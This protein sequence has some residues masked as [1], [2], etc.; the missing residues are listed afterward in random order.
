MK[1]VR[2]VTQAFEGRTVGTI[3][4]V[5][6]TP[7]GVRA[8]LVTEV[9]V[10]DNF[11]VSTMSAVIHPAKWVKNGVADVYADPLDATFTRQNGTFVQFVSD[12]AKVLVKTNA[13]K[14]AAVG[15]KYAEMDKAI[16]DQMEVVFG[17]RR[18]DSAAATQQTMNLMSAKPDLFALEG[19]V[20]DMAVTGYPLGTALNTAIKVKAYAD[21]RIAQIEAYGVFRVKR[22]KQFGD[23][24]AVILA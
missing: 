9:E 10:A 19:L 15:V 6:P 12:A 14:A 23:E 2:V 13:T 3:I 24:R 11:D 20:A 21:L 5:I 18:A 1:Y 16:F 7:A 17:T 22:I 4:D 8:G